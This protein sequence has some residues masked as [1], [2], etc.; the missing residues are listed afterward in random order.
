MTVPIDLI[1]ALL[2]HERRCYGSLEALD[3]IQMRDE[4]PRARA[5]ERWQIVNDWT[6]FAVERELR[7]EAKGMTYVQFMERRR[8]AGG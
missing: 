5:R 4:S 8:E 2:E 7:P 6:R 3:S 1:C